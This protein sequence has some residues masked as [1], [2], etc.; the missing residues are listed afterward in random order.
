M[1]SVKQHVEVNFIV[2]IVTCV[3]VSALDRMDMW[4]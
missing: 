3:M 1:I 2:V 4:L